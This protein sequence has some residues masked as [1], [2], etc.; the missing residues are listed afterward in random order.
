MKIK[1]PIC[2][3]ELIHLNSIT[4]GLTYKFY[5]EFW[6]DNCKIDITTGT[7]KKNIRRKSKMWEDRYDGTIYKDEDEAKEAAREQME[8][9]D[10]IDWGDYPLEKLIRLVWKYCPDEIYDETLEAEERYFDNRFYE[11]EGSEE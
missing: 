2:G 4:Y 10:Y 11:I 6:C 3:K 5:Y 9:D 1:C 8:L 7:D